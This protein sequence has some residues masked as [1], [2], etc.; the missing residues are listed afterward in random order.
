MT[1]QYDSRNVTDWVTPLTKIYNTQSQQLNLF[2]QQQKEV[3]RQKQEAAITIPEVLGQGAR[4]AK[5]SKTLQKQLVT[6]AVLCGT[7]T[8]SEKIELC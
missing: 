7:F 2:L 6:P 5:F 3:D 1:V 4:L 8:L